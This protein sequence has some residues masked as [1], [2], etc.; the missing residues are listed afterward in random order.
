ME[1][2]CYAV[3]YNGEGATNSSSGGVFFMLAQKVIEMFNGQVCGAI[4]NEKFEVEHRFID[5]INDLKKIQGS[6]YV[7]SYIGNCYQE[8]FDYLKK[9][10]TVLFSGTPCQISA[11]YKFL[12]IKE[13]K[14]F[15]NLITVEIICHGVPSRGIF[16]DYIKYLNSKNGDLREYYFKS[17]DKKKDF[18]IKC[19]YD[20]KVKYYNALKDP[21]YAA[22][23]K[24]II[25]RPSCY[26]C[27]F[28]GLNR[29]ADFTIGDFWGIEKVKISKEYENSSVM[30]LNND[31]AIKLVK[32]LENDCLL[33]NVSINEAI[34]E[35]PQLNSST[36]IIKVPYLRDNTFMLWKDDNP[37]E[38]FNYLKNVSIN[39][40]KVFFNYLPKAAI[41]IVKRLKK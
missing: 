32:Y 8:C 6:K 22:F 16:R 24:D 39:R 17:K 25:L 4:F 7:Q 35:Q 34:K 41:K 14:D 15:S 31:K 40:K 2:K 37:K 23:L 5:N 36:R 18:V 30:I 10:T 38:F 1:K 9:G 3:K 21:F 11:L 20:N 26:N 28:C 27:R 33:Y 13:M 12:E 19:V 29:V